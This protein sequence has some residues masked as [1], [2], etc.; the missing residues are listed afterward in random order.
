MAK[1][2]IN[3]VGNNHSSLSSISQKILSFLNCYYFRETIFVTQATIGKTIS[4]KK[5]QLIIIYLCVKWFSTL[6][7][8]ISCFDVLYYFSKPGKW[9]NVHVVF[10]IRNISNDVCNCIDGELFEPIIA[11]ENT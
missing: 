4:I 3:W 11:A 1:Q 2:F 8:C 9:G 6:R 7:P 5:A 10:W